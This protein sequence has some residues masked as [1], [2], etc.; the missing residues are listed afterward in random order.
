[1]A[2]HFIVTDLVRNAMADNF[3]ASLDAG[4][5]AAIEIWEGT[6]PAGPSTAITDG[7]GGY[8][9]LAELLMSA[10]SFGAASNG[11]ITAGA[12]ADD[13]SANKTGT[14][15]FFRMKTASGGTVIAQ[16]TVAA[17]GADMNFNTVA[18]TAGSTV[19]ITSMTVTHPTGV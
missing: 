1:M 18:F 14:A 19:S 3:T 13:T 4:A 10:T 2:N 6:E 9:L 5:Q 11:V 16:G 17:S 8:N 12:I 7:V 15:A